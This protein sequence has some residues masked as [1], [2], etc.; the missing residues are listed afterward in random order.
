MFFIECDS[1]DVCCSI[2]CENEKLDAKHEIAQ[3]NKFFKNV[4]LHQVGLDTV[5]CSDPEKNSLCKSGEKVE[6]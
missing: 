6:D 4:L 3:I 2:C 1:L 5:C